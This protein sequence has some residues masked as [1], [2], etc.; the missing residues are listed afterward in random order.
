MDLQILEDFA[1]FFDTGSLAH[2]NHGLRPSLICVSHFRAPF[3]ITF[4]A[5]RITQIPRVS[6]IDAHL[7]QISLLATYIVSPPS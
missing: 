2:R 6:T 7:A 3:A 5:S 1:S 4:I